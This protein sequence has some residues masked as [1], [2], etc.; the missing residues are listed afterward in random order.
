MTVIP[1]HLIIKT[2]ICN[3]C[4]LTCYESQGACFPLELLYE[5]KREPEEK[6][7]ELFQKILEM[8]E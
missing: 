6:Q 8:V 2:T 5:I 3:E 7:F 1:F 4:K